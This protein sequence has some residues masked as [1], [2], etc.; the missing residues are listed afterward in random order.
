MSNEQAKSRRE[1]ETVGAVAQKQRE[2]DIRLVQG[3][4][5]RLRSEEEDDLRTREGE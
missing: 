2:L 5:S 4:C 3:T 1:F